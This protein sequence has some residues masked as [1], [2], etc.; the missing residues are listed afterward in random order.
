MRS[1]PDKVFDTREEA[2][3]ARDRLNQAP[4][5]YGYGA[6]YLGSNGDSEWRVI[7]W[8]G[9]M[10]ED[11]GDAGAYE[12]S[13]LQTFERIA[14]DH[15]LWIGSEGIRFD[16]VELEF[17]YPNTELVLL[18]RQVPDDRFDRPNNPD[19]VFGSRW[20]IWPTS[21]LDPADEAFDLQI[22]FEEFLDTDR[23]ARRFRHGPCDPSTITWLT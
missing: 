17:K 10:S 9:L 1:D 2:E 22:N 18:F 8:R 11:I 19:C 12:A 5:E 14:A 23:R 21:H 7:R 20:T 3:R 16:S 13:F 15:D 6:W 4:P